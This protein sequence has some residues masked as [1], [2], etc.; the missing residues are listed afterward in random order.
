VAGADPKPI[1]SIVP[2]MFK[3]EMPAE[4]RKSNWQQ[5]IVAWSRKVDPR[6]QPGDV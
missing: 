2:D 1:I 4:P 3:G 6:I 5:P